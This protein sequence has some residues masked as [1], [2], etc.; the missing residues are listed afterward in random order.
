[1]FMASQKKRKVLAV[2]LAVIFLVFALCVP[3]LHQKIKQKSLSADLKPSPTTETIEGTTDLSS[4]PED[5]SLPEIPSSVS[6]STPEL[7]ADLSQMVWPLEGQVLR[8][9]GISYAQTFSDYRYHDG[10]DIQAARGAEVVAA[11]PG[12]VISKEMT[13]GE[14]V[15]LVLDHGQGWVSVYSHL[16]EAYLQVDNYCNV[17]DPLGTVNQ[18]GLQEILE[19]PHLHFI[20]RQDDQIVNPLD[21]LPEMP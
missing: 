9:V 10:L 1:M 20:L 16:D 5:S 4:S 15:K 7:K 2:Y 3:V 6:D 13:K 21:Y 14:G 8:G 12:V 19:G 11:L 17:G 18:P